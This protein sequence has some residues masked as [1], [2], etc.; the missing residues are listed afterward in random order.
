MTEKKKSP[1][2]E[3]L[4]LDVPDASLFP[5]LQED[6]AK[7]AS[8]SSPEKRSPA[9]DTF[10]RGLKGLVDPKSLL[11]ADSSASSSNVEKGPLLPNPPPT[12][13]LR[14]GFD[15]PMPTQGDLN[16][17]SASLTEIAPEPLTP[18]SA[19]SG[20]WER[21]GGAAF[22]DPRRVEPPPHT[23]PISAQ[24]T[25]KVS[26]SGN[27]PNRPASAQPTQK[28]SSSGNY[29]TFSE[30]VREQSRSLWEQPQEP[31]PSPQPAPSSSQIQPDPSLAQPAPS[32]SQIQPDPSLAQPAPSSS[33]IQP[34]PSLA[35]PAP[36]SLQMQP[37]PSLA[38]QDPLTP[39]AAVASL[40][41][42]EGQG[43]APKGPFN[44][45]TSPSSTMWP[46]SE[47]SSP[48][49]DGSFSAAFW[50]IV[51][52]APTSPDDDLPPP[53]SHVQA[54]P[55]Q[56]SPRPLVDPLKPPSPPSTQS[57]FDRAS[58]P[59]D[60]RRNPA[61]DDAEGHSPA[62]TFHPYALADSRDFGKRSPSGGY[63]I[64][65][66]DETQLED[67][68]KPAMPA[69]SK[70]AWDTSTRNKAKSVEL[71]APPTRT[72]STKIE[73]NI[74]EA[75]Q[76]S[77]TR[78][79]SSKIETNIQEATQASPTR[80]SSSKIETNIQEAAQS[81]RSLAA[82]EREV[83]LLRAAQPTDEMPTFTLWPETE[84]PKPH[85]TNPA[86]AVWPSLNESAAPP[87]HASSAAFWSLA[88]PEPATS[89]KT[90]LPSVK[91]PSDPSLAQIVLT[92]ASDLL[93]LSDFSDV[94]ELPDPSNDPQFLHLANP[95]AISDV[96]N[97]S[98]HPNLSEMSD[99]MR[100]ADSSDL[101]DVM[102]FS[103]AS[104]L[105]DV[106]GFADVSSRN[107]APALRRDASVLK[108]WQQPS[109]MAQAM[110]MWGE[111]PHAPAALPVVDS[112]PTQRPSSHRREVRQSA[113]DTLEEPTVSETRSSKK[114]TPQ[115]AKRKAMID[116]PH[117]P[118]DPSLQD[119]SRKRRS[120]PSY[121]DLDVVRKLQSMWM[122]PPE[123]QAYEREDRVAIGDTGIH[124]VVG[125][126]GTN[127]MVPP[128]AKAA[129][130]ESGPLPSA[131]L[132]QK[133]DLSK[134]TEAPNDTEQA[135]IALVV[136]IAQQK[137]PKPPAAEI[138]RTV[139]PE[140][141]Q[142][143]AGDAILRRV[144]AR[145]ESIQVM[146]EDAMWQI[147][148][149]RDLDLKRTVAIKRLKP[150]M[151]IPHAVL[152]MAEEVQIM[153]GLAHPNIPEIHDVGVDEQGRYYFVMEHLK[154]ETMR[155][156][157]KKLASGDVRYQ[158]RFPLQTRLLIFREV[159]RAVEYAHRKG[160][161]HRN[162]NPAHVVVGARDEVKLLGWE[163]AYKFHSMG[164]DPEP[165]GAEA[166][167]AIFAPMAPIPGL[168]TSEVFRTRDGRIQG[169]PAYMAPEQIRNLSLLIDERS[170]VYGLATLFYEW[171]GLRYYLGP[172]KT[173]DDLSEGIVR[174]EPVPLHLLRSNAQPDLPW[175][176]SQFA[177]RALQK[178]PNQRFGSAAE[179]R[180][181]L[182][183]VIVGGGITHNG[184]LPRALRF[185]EERPIWAGSLLILFVCTLILSGVQIATWLRAF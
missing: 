25:Q 5:A 141:K 167:D 124:P 19:L 31:A 89:Q 181:A 18:F 106:M 24:P 169:S 174:E 133:I 117:D 40:S 21:W 129:R 1:E 48:H 180:A 71:S 85:R 65:E 127:P 64:M 78:T 56:P 135:E 32:S 132:S 82:K 143:A 94:S 45:G 69:E 55:Y 66:Q 10:T 114:P 58:A 47:P 16:A 86:S 107:D 136:S 146:S 30:V 41:L 77:P 100:F 160:I 138:R 59:F 183:A 33:Q 37:D 109:E 73:T 93:E 34:D 88:E 43:A 177:T 61:L 153:A 98:R 155:S 108:H 163:L 14:L 3:K 120:T 147:E 156:I 158:K 116:H 105:S 184:T 44:A 38:A 110:A 125:Q 152:R 145:Y 144:Q 171:I 84:E 39:I 168:V 165:M 62:P 35:Q 57:H 26:S 15:G 151:H 103:D 134:S 131:D 36:S 67:L 4:S 6:G 150:E 74:Q 126:R 96:P 118:T 91:A 76:A 46:A 63:A 97:P 154:G 42:Q 51:E 22:L 11:E 79:S 122:L 68:S 170:D 20:S 49:E 80:T 102:E 87:V 54:S 27:A 101:S 121:A 29:Q 159:L 162:L 130:G 137:L 111:A 140:Y 179:M 99:A 72:S 83:Q 13:L 123:L 12:H 17:V 50:A 112:P 28:V 185:L 115:E 139:L 104:D 172:K 119:G 113:G 164:Q 178:D 166:M 128:L 2:E 52:D 60:P 75:T 8:A 176:V 81:S 157:L 9:K 142:R 7:R 95:S 90:T 149:V 70:S 23:S 182:E 173:L 53:A 175:S 92:D 161:L 148:L